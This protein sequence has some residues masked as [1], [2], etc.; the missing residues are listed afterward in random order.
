MRLS[1]TMAQ[2]GLQLF[3]L[4]MVLILLIAPLYNQKPRNRPSPY[5]LLTA[6]IQSATRLSPE[7]LYFFQIHLSISL[8]T[9]LVCLQGDCC[10]PKHASVQH[11]IHVLQRPEAG[12]TQGGGLDAGPQNR[13]AKAGLQV[14]R[15]QERALCQSI[16]TVYILEKPSGRT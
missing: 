9:L 2:T 14:M 12:V 13:N 6:H 16:I 7:R 11:L 5:L 1:L 10:K 4:A 8:T 15:S 3:L